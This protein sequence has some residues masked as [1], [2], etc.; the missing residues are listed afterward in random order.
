MFAER[1]DDPLNTDRA[2]EKRG[3][4][5]LM[6]SC[7]NYEQIFCIVENEEDKQ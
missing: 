7:K 1:E 4:Q 5:T 2:G 3:K 6:V